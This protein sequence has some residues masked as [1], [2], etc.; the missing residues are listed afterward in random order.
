M[1]AI[2]AGMFGR[3]TIGVVLCLGLLVGAAKAITETV[4]TPAPTPVQPA[5]PA[6]VSAPDENSADATTAA[7]EQDDSNPYSAIVH[8]NVFHLT[9]PPKPQPKEDPAILNL[10]KVNI[11][12]FR[13][14]DGE[15]LRALFAT[16]PKDPKEAAKYFNLAEGEKEDILELKRIDPDQES[17]DVIIAGTPT[18]LTVKS[19]SF[20]LPISAPKAGTGMASGGNPGIIARPPSLAPA[21]IP[22]QQVNPA[23]YGQGQQNPGGVIVA[24]GGTVTTAA[25]VP[26]QFPQTPGVP[27]QPFGGAY[28]PSGYNPNA[29]PAV[30]NPAAANGTPGSTGG[31]SPLR[32]IPT[33]GIR[34]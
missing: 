29:N 15:P 3:T 28:N 13:K 8:A 10:P 23:N 20:V 16:V 30:P 21:P 4:P 27:Q 11:T 12:G 5:P 7:P 32:A 14:R 24:G 18:T 33:R 19:N 25:A 9:E 1:M 22:Q 26:P 31:D 17:V 6:A 2:V 34:H